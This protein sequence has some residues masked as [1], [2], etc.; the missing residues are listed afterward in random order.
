MQ[1]TAVPEGPASSGEIQEVVVAGLRNS[2]ISAETI[3]RDSLG[4]VD[5]ISPQDIGEASGRQPG[6]VFATHYRRIDRYF[7]GEGAFVTVR[8]FGPE[9]NTVLLNGRQI[10]TPTD[11]AQASGRAFSFDTLASELVSGVEVY[12]TSTARLQSGGVGSTISIKTAQPFD[13]DGFKFMARP[14]PTTRRIPARPHRTPRFCSADRFDDGTFR[15]PGVGQL[16]A[17][18][19]PDKPG[20][21]RWLDRQRRHSDFGDQRRRRGGK[22]REQSA[23]QSVRSSRLRH[24]GVVRA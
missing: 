12:K 4:I 18:Q 11:P 21:H 9:F 3:K 5:A 1:E 15:R 7:N 16:P 23:G 13:Y 2:L 8:G 6:G 14:M 10:A 24:P 20:N 19:G 17:A 22:N